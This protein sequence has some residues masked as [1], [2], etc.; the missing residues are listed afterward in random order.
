MRA[1]ARTSDRVRAIFVA[2]TAVAQVVVGSFGGSNTGSISDANASPVT[3]A[4]WAFAIWILIYA[5][6]LAL[7]AYQLAPSQQQRRVHR[8]SG[9]WL[10]GAFAAST[11]W[12]P[13]FG[14][15]VLW[16]AQILIILLTVCLVFA[17][18]GF[19]LTGPAATAG[20]IGLLRLPVMLYLGWATVATAAGF[21]TTF[22][23]WGMPASAR[24]VTEICVVLVLSAAIM[25]L[26]V[27]GRLLAV[28]GFLLAA[29]WGLV[30]V[31]VN[32]ASGSVRL[33]AILAIIV[34]VCVVF[35]RTVRS[36]EGRAVLFG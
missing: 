6:C 25:S 31:A 23:S 14:A 21:A 3:P 33:A 4:G 22:R 36:P 9:W 20:E 7:A 1:V 11:V 27:V 29:C 18:R 34:L 26:F 2:L 15:Q 32:T 28:A 24:W 12:V 17:A 5:G 19:L 10:V 16:L 8:R 13:I 30:A 35:G